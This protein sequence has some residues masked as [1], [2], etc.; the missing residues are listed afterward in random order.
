M[1]AGNDAAVKT[2]RTKIDHV[3]ASGMTAGTLW[4]HYKNKKVYQIVGYSVHTD[5]CEATICYQSLETQECWS[6]RLDEFVEVADKVTA[7]RRFTK[8]G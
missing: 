2:A 1:A 4:R 5:T 6:R 8:V 7:E 3:I